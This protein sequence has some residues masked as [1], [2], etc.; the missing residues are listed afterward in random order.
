MSSLT[1]TPFSMHD[2]M[3][4]DTLTE[5]GRAHVEELAKTIWDEYNAS[6][7][8]ITILEV[9][10]YVIA[11]LSYRT[12]FEMQDIFTGYQ[13]QKI[14][15]RDLYLADQI[16]PN[17]PWTIQDLRKVL[18]DKPQYNP[19]PGASALELRNIWPTVSKQSEE[20][21][22]FHEEAKQ[23]WFEKDLLGNLPKGVDH[24]QEAGH[25]KIVL[26]GLYNLQLEFEPQP[27]ED[28][29]HLQNLNYNDFEQCFQYK[30]NTYCM[31]ILMP[32]WEDV[33]LS[34]KDI[35]PNQSTL[36]IR[37]GRKHLI[38][39]DKR[40]YDEYFYD[41]F[42]ELELKD[43]LGTKVPV[44]FNIRL[45]DYLKS[46]IDVGG[47]SYDVQVQFI[48]WHEV[49]NRLDWDYAINN[50]QTVPTAIGATPFP[51]DVS[52][53]TN[54][55]VFDVALE[56][57][58]PTTPSGDTEFQQARVTFLNPSDITA[59]RAQLPAVMQAIRAAFTPAG[60]PVGRL[61]QEFAEL[62]LEMERTVLDASSGYLANYIE[63]LQWLY[64][65]VYGSLGKGHEN[66]FTYASRFR[67]VCED[68]FQFSMARLQEVAV[69]GNVIIDPEY[70]PNKVLAEI[71][72][73][74]DQFISPLAQFR[75]LNELKATGQRLS[76]AFNGPTL[77]HGFL[78]EEEL[79]ALQQ[80]DAIYTSDLVNFIMEVEGVIAIE[81]LNLSN[82]IDNR[83]M[84]SHVL[85]CLSLTN[86][87]LYRP[88]FSLP[89]SGL[90][91]T[92][93]EE[94]YTLD[95]NVIRDW[96][97]SFVQE[98]VDAQ[99]PAGRPYE[100]FTLPTGDD[101]QIESYYSLQHDLPEVYG[102]GEYGLPLDATEERK[103][104]AKQLKGYLLFFDQLM[105][106]YLSQVA[107]LRELFSISRDAKE[108]YKNQPLYDLPHVQPLLKDFVDSGDTWNNFIGDANNAYRLHLNDLAE[109]DA[110]YTDRRNRFLDHLIG[111]FSE[112]FN[113]YAT[114][115][116][117]RHQ[118]LL[119]I[120]SND[121]TV[122]QNALNDYQQQR[123][124][125]ASQLI[126]DKICFLEE[127]PVISSE[128]ARA[129]NYLIGPLWDQAV[130]QPSTDPLEPA[131]WTNVNVSGYKK[132]LCRMLGIKDY[133]HR[134]IFS[135][136][137]EGMH[138]VEH[139]LLRPRTTQEALLNINSTTFY[140]SERD[141]YSFKMTIALPDFAG[142]FKAPE[143]RRFVERLIRTETPAHIA[144][145]LR[146]MDQEC[147]LQF[148]KLF[149]N[150]LAQLS[151][152][153]IAGP[154][155]PQNRAYGLYVRAQTS[156]V[157][158]LNGS[159][160]QDIDLSLTA[161]DEQSSAFTPDF[162]NHIGYQY[163]TTDIYTL[164]CLPPNGILRFYKLAGNGSW[165]LLDTIANVPG[166]Y[167]I[168]PTKG[169]AE[170]YGQTGNYRIDYEYA[171]ALVDLY[172]DVYRPAEPVTI[173]LWYIK[174]IVPPEGKC[175]EL[176]ARFLNGYFFSFNA[177]GGT[178]RFYLINDDGTR[179]L[180][181][182]EQNAGQ[183]YIAGL[184]STHGGGT[185]IVN[186]ELDGQSTEVCMQWDTIR[187]RAFDGINGG[188]LMPNNSGVI[189]I[190]GEEAEVKVIFEPA[191]GT[192]TR[193]IE[194]PNGGWMIDAVLNTASD[195]LFFTATKKY[196]Y[197]YQHLGQNDSIT[198]EFTKK[199]S[200][201]ALEIWQGDVPFPPNN[202]DLYLFDPIYDTGY[203]LHASPLGGLLSY[204]IVRNG[205]T[206]QIA[207]LPM[208]GPDTE[209]Q[210]F[211][212]LWKT[213]GPGDYLWEYELN[214]AVA[215]LRWTFVEPM[216]RIFG[217][218]M[219]EQQRNNAN[220]MNFINADPAAYEVALGPQEGH[221]IITAET[222]PW[223]GQVR[224]DEPMATSFQFVPS[225]WQPGRYRLQYE[226]APYGMQDE[227]ILVI[228][229]NVIEN[230]ENSGSN[231]IKT[232]ID[233]ADLGIGPISVSDPRQ[234]LPMP[235]YTGG[236]E[237]EFPEKRERPLPV[238]EPIE[239]PV[240]REEPRTIPRFVEPVEPQAEAL[241]VS[242]KNLE[243]TPAVSKPKELFYIFDVDRS[244]DTKYAVELATHEPAESY[245]WT[246]DGRYR[247]KSDTPRITLD[248]AK[249]E[250]YVIAL[251]TS[252]D[253]G[254]Q[255]FELEVTKQLLM[256]Y[257]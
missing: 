104:Q 248:F 141:P 189:S 225:Q 96:F 83:L 74:I 37:N 92:V 180:V 148:E 186:Y 103:G 201:V 169:F 107:N 112:N 247:A 212:D 70:N 47:I 14:T 197:T 236:L 13:G 99:I 58:L 19:Q 51:V 111:R 55:L 34:L 95:A 199:E 122:I 226:Y 121:P 28:R 11:D 81:G 50:G 187:I 211:G 68:Y 12:S 204:S 154:L 218:G 41:Y 77:Q 16:L 79:E 200:D 156:L 82:Y 203:Y 118:H 172:V 144:I 216:V 190:T 233:P 23:L 234:D 64:D 91:A 222:G 56:W 22:W 31:T 196:F 27:N 185:Y 229:G 116:Y 147:G 214:G 7:P 59:L 127:Y 139:I 254:K 206:I 245:R 165:T 195:I 44:D 153:A 80:K 4:Y 219:I 87:D 3:L 117:Q 192:A 162:N 1:T 75:T 135:L 167:A 60:G 182:T 131:S 137:E 159:C 36:S 123:Q 61:I 230:L 146:W 240:E 202:G 205:N 232:P 93:E 166:L 130:L 174:E 10:A 106:N 251:A 108:T 20:Q 183:V 143:Y 235:E 115:Q 35:D 160:G 100:E 253:D 72:F 17:H 193:Y 113:E 179:T 257:L 69:F 73:L 249:A 246:V 66:L 243:K 133:S 191:G 85:N 54:E 176:N 43:Q 171:G 238:V 138:I 2:S 9:L 132:R 194:D 26:N 101:M 207:T 18:L 217:L 168:D 21:L 25:Q 53:N 40:N 208:N 231:L 90:V 48:D 151:N 71:Y 15:N 126:E 152:F 198:I 155:Y 164:E 161:F 29:P 241:P 220:E 98:K 42:A 228:E 88:K 181:Q 255:Q 49:A 239:E 105:A 157:N 45:D 63:K 89:K 136:G 256:K 119:N 150:W 129:Y 221:L 149:Q 215:N 178:A 62:E 24:P 39:V 109:S 102:V 250:A 120:N 124:L 142:R 242:S 145:D 76:D 125:T 237:E 5:K 210:L 158:F 128:R 184:L 223:A 8:G 32:Y 94:R 46:T 134:S 213:H 65:R 6:D 57:D 30:G 78:N 163:G 33:P 84:G 188:E 209:H 175:Y 140:Q 252:G 114:A 52:P 227:L 224:M 244:G 38:A 177:P 170:K 97:D 110:V 67:N 173:D 86:S